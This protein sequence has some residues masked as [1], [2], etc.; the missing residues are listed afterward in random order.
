MERK[1]TVRILQAIKWE[2]CTLEDLDMAKKG[3]SLLIR[4][5]NNFIS[6]NYVKAKIEDTQ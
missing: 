2:D 3:K 5:Q 1:T 4:R 6:T